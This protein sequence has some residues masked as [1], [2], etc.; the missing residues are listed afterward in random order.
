[1]SYATLPGQLSIGSSLKLASGNLVL[2][3]S[4]TD[5]LSVA[6]QPGFTA[7]TYNGITY[8]AQGIA[9]GVSVNVPATP[10]WNSATTDVDFCAQPLAATI[11]NN[12]PTTINSSVIF[13]NYWPNIF[14]NTQGSWNGA[15]GVYTVVT[16]GKYAVSFSA[17]FNASGVGNR[18][19][20]IAKYQSF[21][22]GTYNVATNTVSAAT[23]TNVSCATVTT[24]QA[25]DRLSCIATQNSG[26]N[27]SGNFFIS[28]TYLHV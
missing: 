18:T 28:I 6:P 4:D 17:Q 26:G 23:S 2:E 10:G 21:N 12:T 13:A 19:A 14:T 11:P 27:L 20:S 24:C 9:T 7:G 15:T 1:M 5:S 16:P 22:T 8:N 25:G 3:S